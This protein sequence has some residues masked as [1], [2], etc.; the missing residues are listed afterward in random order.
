M[1]MT[2]YVLFWYP[3]GVKL[4]WD[5]AHKTRTW[6]LLGVTFKKSDKHPYHF[7]MAIPLGHVS[8]ASSPRYTSMCKCMKIADNCTSIEDFHVNDVVFVACWVG[9]LHSVF[10]STVGILYRQADPTVGHLQFS[11]N[12]MTNTPGYG[13]C[14]GLELTG[15]GTVRVKYNPYSNL[16]LQSCG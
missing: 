16:F 7:Y 9:H 14:S 6:Y 3:L 4:T 5:H 11:E 2:G 13:G 10:S 8:H 15:D 12:K 1:I